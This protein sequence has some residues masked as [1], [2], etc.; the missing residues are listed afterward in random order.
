MAE[1]TRLTNNEFTEI[2]SD[3]G[4]SRLLMSKDYYLT[5]ILYLLKD[6]KGIYFKGGTA[7]QKCFL[8]HSRLSEDVDYTLTRSL[9]EVRAEIESVL[10]SSK[11]FGKITQDKDVEGFVRL[12]VHYT[13]FDDE[14]SFIFI[15]LNE[16]GKLLTEP[17]KYSLKH[18]YPN[19]PQ[20]E[21]PCLSRDEM[22]AEKMTA[23][24]S[25]NKPRDH[26]DL[27]KKKCAQVKIEFDIERMFNRANKLHKKWDADMEALLSFEVKF[28]E[29][30]QTLAK[31]FKLSD[32]KEKK[33]S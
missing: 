8:N 30:M 7:L 17:K 10:D 33:R 18:F 24:I 12:V 27:V 22:F 1:I 3:S 23:A 2:V 9:K 5:V 15:D 28:V 11:L 21:V 26:F 19:I 29:V 6:I 31:E 32:V 14:N 25:R 4:F 16:R 20:F 13:G